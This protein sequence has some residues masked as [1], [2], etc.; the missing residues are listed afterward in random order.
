MKIAYIKL[1]EENK[2]NIKIIEEIIIEA[3]RG[4]GENGK[5]TPEEFDLEIKSILA[6]THPSDKMILKLKEVILI[7]NES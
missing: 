6:Y 7:F 2:K 1:D 4:N 5:L 3:G